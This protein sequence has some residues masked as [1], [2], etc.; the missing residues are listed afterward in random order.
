MALT[1]KGAFF[2]FWEFEGV[3]PPQA[4]AILTPI[5]STSKRSR[6]RPEKHSRKE[7]I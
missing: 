5:Q 1:P 7:Q 4:A 6:K 3:L 2:E